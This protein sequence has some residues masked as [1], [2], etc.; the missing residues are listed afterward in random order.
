MI[1]LRYLLAIVRAL[2]I[3]I[4]MFWF[5]LGYAISIP[6][7]GNTPKRA[8]RMRRN[9]LRLCILIL[10]MKLEL[11]GLEHI[12]DH[13]S[14]YV[15]NHR[16]FAD[17][18]YLCRY[19]DAY[20]IAKA[21][22]GNIPL[23]AQGIRLTG[24]IFVNRDIKDSRSATRVAMVETIESG[25][26]V[27][28]YPEGT[29][30]GGVTTKEYKPGTFLEA[31]ANGYTVVPVAVEYRDERALWTEGSMESQFIKHFGHWHNPAK[32]TFLPPIKNDDG[33]QLMQ[34]A[35]DATDR[36]LEQMQK[37]WSRVF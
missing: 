23:L 37:G 13:P 29:T 9:Y 27:A 22:L 17:P 18:F 30:H 26:N 6:I 20:V 36:E 25:Y 2:L 34:S 3:V 28:V 31:A 15:C 4:L 12:Q 32:M 14:L 5:V 24:V 19:L 10:N 16:S 33:I 11:K 8:F 1:V 35:K 7:L 21:E